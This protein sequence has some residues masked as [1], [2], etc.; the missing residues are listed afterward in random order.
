M[1]NPS[2]WIEPVDELT[3]D[4]LPHA[5]ARTDTLDPVPTLR[6]VRTD[7][8]PFLFHLFSSIKYSELGAMQL[9]KA[10][11]N[12]LIWMQFRAHEQHY[13]NLGKVDDDLI[14]LGGEAVGRMIVLR[15]EGAIHLADI[16]LLPERCGQGIGTT[17]IGRLQ[18]EARDKAC[19]LRLRAAPSGRAARLY[20]RTGFA[21]SDDN[22]PYRLMEWFPDPE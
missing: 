9:D 16:S 10:A 2:K 22:L 19:P 7:D 4:T 17:L 18:D 12:Q 14:R 21:F 1:E 13:R 6:P 11:W 3:G 15:G 5:D 8:D 20:L